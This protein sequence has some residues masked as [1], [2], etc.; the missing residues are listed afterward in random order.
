MI[1][2]LKFYPQAFQPTQQTEP[3]AAFDTQANT[4]H[5]YS[6]NAICLN[7]NFA[8]Q[9]RPELVISSPFNSPSLS[10]LEI[11]NYL[12][13]FPRPLMLEEKSCVYPYLVLLTC[14]SADI[15]YY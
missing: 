11:S 15:N 13:M 5:G 1:Y 9:G 3:Q 10:L 7:M 2:Q 6:I 8:H 14:L 4:L 12:I